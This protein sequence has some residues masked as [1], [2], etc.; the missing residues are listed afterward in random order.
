MLLHE[1]LFG[2]DKIDPNKIALYMDNEEYNYESIIKDSISFSFEIMKRG[3]MKGD[4][5]ITLLEN[6]YEFIISTYGILTSGCILVPLNPKLTKEKIVFII[7]DTDPS[8]ILISEK[9]FQSIFNGDEDFPFLI[10]EKNISNEKK[11][12]RSN[13]EI[14]DCDIAAILYTSGST[15]IPKGVT[16]THLNMVTA[17]RSITQY[18]N[19]SSNDIFLNMLPFSFDYGLYQIF[20]SF[21]CGGSL[22]IH[23]DIIF[24]SKIPEIIKKR[25]VT[26]LPIV[27]AL[28]QILLRLKPDPYDLVSIRYITNT[29]QNIPEST[30]KGLVDLIPKVKIF[31]M[32]GLTE[33]KRI[34]YLD[35][36]KILLKPNSVGKAIPNVEVFLIDNEGNR[37][38]KPYSRGELVVRG[39]NVMLGYWKNK[40]ETDN[41]LREGYFPME[42]VLFT[43]DI[44]EF[45]EDGDL[46]FISRKDDVFKVGGQKVSPIEI[47]KALLQHGSINEA[48]VIKSQDK[49][50]GNSIVAIVSVEGVINQKEIKE[51]IK[52]KLEDHLVPRLIFI[53]TSLPKNSNGKVD[54]QLLEKT[55]GTNF[56]EHKSLF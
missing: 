28:G 46:Y 30:I 17:L 14:I 54:K 27:P 43:G 49:I 10:I 2:N 20:L 7:Q 8:L 47:E 6:S 44:F 33:C 13:V 51:Y 37:I 38:E 11:E 55:Y 36:S 18:L 15:G 1:T 45:D 40:I 9:V 3:L 21:F 50:L 42:K 5:V 26:A 34:S 25:K 12:K 35:P 19:N 39:S 31:S 48:A 29:A 52:G 22:V 4:R 41:A 53:V 32:Y 56:N 16:L 23:N 24:S